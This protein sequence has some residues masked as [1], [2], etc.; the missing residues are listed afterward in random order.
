LITEPDPTVGPPLIGAL[1]RMPVDAVRARML[2]GLHGAGFTDLVTAHFTVL[3]YPGPDNRRPSDLA[4]EARMTRQAM[5]YL[6]GELERLGYL[7]RDPDPDDQRS[8]RVHLTERGY[9][10][11]RTIRDVVRE[12]EAEWEQELGPTNFAQLRRL[13][14]ELNSTRLLRETRASQPRR[15]GSL[16]PPRAASARGQPRT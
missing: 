16:R 3:R 9:A 8:K 4:D 11:R 15:D 13:L 12:I 10:A 14:V 5:N 7:T 1:M 2:A 6:L